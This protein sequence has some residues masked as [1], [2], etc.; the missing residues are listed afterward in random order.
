MSSA[1]KTEVPVSQLVA[2]GG[3]RALSVTAVVEVQV[4]NFSML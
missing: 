3:D 2:V 1:D 4:W